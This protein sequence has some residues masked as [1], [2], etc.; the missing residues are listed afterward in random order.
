[1]PQTEVVLR[2]RAAI[3]TAIRFPHDAN[4]AAALS[5]AKAYPRAMRSVHVN[6]NL[7]QRRWEWL[8]D[9][10]FYPAL[11][12]SDED[13]QVQGTISPDYTG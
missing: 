11:D 5:I 13:D 1:M 6:H 7:G 9:H 2:L 4:V 12:A 3:D 8:S 10:G